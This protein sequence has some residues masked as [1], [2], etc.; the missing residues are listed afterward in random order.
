MIFIA[1]LFV[2]LNLCHYMHDD[3]RNEC[4]ASLIVNENQEHTKG[5]FCTEFLRDGIA[6]VKVEEPVRETSIEPLLVVPVLRHILP[7]N[8][9]PEPLQKVQNV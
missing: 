8:T 4:R 2:L 3:T 5:L 1:G 6:E 9:Q 7:L